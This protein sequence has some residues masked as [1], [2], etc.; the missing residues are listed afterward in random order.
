G[1]GAFNFG[2]PTAALWSAHRAA[3]PFV[4]VILN[5]GTYL[6]SRQPVRRLFP[7]GAA[8]RRDDFPETM[9]GGAIDYAALARSCGGTG[10][11]V[12]R[13]EQMPGAMRRAL[14]CSAGGRCAVIDARLPAPG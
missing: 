11:V 8:Q 10:E 4:T 6:A 7:E 2:V 9:L 12:D 3:A 5:N 1:D 13:P 14:A